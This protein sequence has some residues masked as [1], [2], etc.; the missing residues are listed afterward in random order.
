MFSLLPQLT[1]LALLRRRRLLLISALFFLIPVALF[2]FFLGSSSP[3]TVAPHMPPG[4]A[5][6]LP[7]NKTTTR[8]PVP[9]LPLEANRHVHIFYYA[10]YGNINMDGQYV[11][12]KHKRIAHWNPERAKKFSTSEHSPPDDIGA[13]FY[14]KL[15]PYSSHDSTVY[16]EH[17]EQIRK[18]GI[19][20]HINLEG[21]AY[22]DELHA[23]QTFM[24]ED[25][26]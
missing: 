7:E 23:F 1:M 14:P 8:A 26:L 2:Y 3:N 18:T 10:W 19:G 21:A 17:F 16:H 15:G 11:H 25:K 12:W 6:E 20:E 22:S 5:P 24:T 13:N 9:F 4:L